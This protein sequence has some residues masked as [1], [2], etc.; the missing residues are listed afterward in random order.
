MMLLYLILAAIFFAS[1]WMG[2]QQQ[3]RLFACTCGMMLGF[4]GNK[5]CG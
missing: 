3:T 1:K 4:Q 2:A 5:G